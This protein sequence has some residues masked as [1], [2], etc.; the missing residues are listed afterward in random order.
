M[1]QK[2]ASVDQDHITPNRY[3]F[4]KMSQ[5]GFC[6]VLV[7]VADDDADED[8][9]CSQLQATQ[10]LQGQMQQVGQSGTSSA[11]PVTLVKSVAAP[12]V[13]IPVSINVTMAQGQQKAALREC[14]CSFGK[15][16]GGGLLGWM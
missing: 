16:G 2:A 12:A 9:V 15:E 10:I 4:T 5:W 14:P 8:D 3:L 7:S 11:A 1:T 13:P 6:A